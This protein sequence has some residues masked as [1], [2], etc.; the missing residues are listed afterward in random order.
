MKASDFSVTEGAT[1]T[2][3]FNP[4]GDRKNPSVEFVHIVECQTENLN[5]AF[6]PI[7]YPTGKDAGLPC[8]NSTKKPNP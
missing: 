3:E 6:V 5:F 8:L 2:I 4:N 1:G 7:K